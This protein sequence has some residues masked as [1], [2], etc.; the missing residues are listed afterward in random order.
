MKLHIGVIGAG[1]I[2]SSRHIPN[3]LKIDGVELTAVANRRADNARLAAERFGF[4]KV[5]DTWQEVVDDAEV[6]AVFICTPPILHK[7]ISAYCIAKGKH[8]FS[9]ARMAMDLT[10]ALD[11]LRLDESTPLTT[12]LC[13]AP[14]Y[15]KVEPYVLELLG[16]GVIGDI[17]HV[18]LTHPSSQYVDPSKPLHWRQRADLQGINTLDV[19]ITGEVLNK[20][21]GPL[22]SLS[23]EGQTWVSDRPQDADGKS[24][25]ELPDSVTVIGRFEKGPILTA[26]FTGAVEGGTHSM[27]IYGSQGTL[28]CYPEKA[29]ILLSRNG[30]EQRIAIPDDKLKPWT[31]EADFIRAIRQGT[32]GAPS[33]RDGA[34]YMA[35]TQAIT[36]SMRSGRRVE[37][38]KIP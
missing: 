7:E 29:H 26:L 15:M 34:L 16:E 10:E 22:A 24:L 11:M 19:G 12:M 6:N 9:Q 17:R 1:G 14:N 27:V 35:F 2:A 3:L 18:Y 33:F 13:P 5:Y 23:A 25:V 20:W 38:T 31:V 32:K 30:E 36:D 4:R 21:F 8:V 28:T 37:L